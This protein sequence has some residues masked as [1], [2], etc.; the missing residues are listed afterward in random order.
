MLALAL[1]SQMKR[2]PLTDW[3]SPS[4]RTVLWGFDL[5]FIWSSKIF[6]MEIM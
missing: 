1:R 6:H 5:M 3:S 4:I 2:P